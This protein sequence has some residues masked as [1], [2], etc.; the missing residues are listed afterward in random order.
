MIP[1]PLR[2]AQDPGWRFEH[3]ELEAG[4]V[5]E[6]YLTDGQNLLKK[7]PGTSGIAR[8]RFEH[9]L[10]VAVDMCTSAI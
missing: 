4:K 5:P 9:Q 1:S 2:C 10:L 6:C 8:V 3:Q 7:T